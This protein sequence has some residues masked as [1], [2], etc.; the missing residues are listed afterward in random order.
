MNKWLIGFVLAWACLAGCYQHIPS[1]DLWWLLA[2]GRLISQTGS[3]PAT[4]PFS[5][6]AR[7]L[8]WHNDQWLAGWLAFQVYRMA[9]LEGLH[10]M[11]ALIITVSLG[12][13]L[14][15]G[16]R[17]RADGEWGWLAPALGIT[18]LCAEGRYF[19]DVRAYLSTYFGLALL[20]RWLQ[21]R[22]R[23]HPIAVFSLFALWA[24]LHAGVSSGLLL[25]GLAA[26]IRRSRQLLSLTGLAVLAT[27]CN[28]S[29]LW[30][31]LHPLRLLGS[32]W[33]HYLNE[34]APAWRRPDLFTL[35]FFGLGLWLAWGAAARPR[36]QKDDFVLLA[37]ALFSLTGW[38]H[39]PLF[40]LLALPRWCYH[41]RGP[42]WTWR[43]TA[44]GLL[45]WAGLKPLQLS[46]PSQSLQLPLPDG[47]SMPAFPVEACNWLA[48]HSARPARLFH[49]YGLG[50]YLLWRDFP[51]FID[52]RAVQVYPWETYRQYLSVALPTRSDGEDPAPARARFEEFCRRNDIKVAMLFTQQK[53]AGLWLVQE[54]KRWRPV[55]SDD[56][57]TVMVTE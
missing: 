3:I 24:N 8:P 33:G 11:K 22:D 4:D 39:I 47:R 37:F 28:P 52:G 45:F 26:L 43:L 19:F 38:R 29:G 21:L 41:L 34:W 6:S 57:V 20:W 49:P 7:G 44:L 15:T 51:V 17:L 1:P 5:W 53:E 42:N 31:L 27:C 55:Y 25:L 32:P 46:D 12:M 2:D 16:R 18:L 50:G 13:L 30:L 14:D 23:L 48:D 35:Q 9:G 36:W 56:L 10:L 54:N 40:A